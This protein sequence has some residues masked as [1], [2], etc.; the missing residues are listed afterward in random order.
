VRKVDSE[1]FA[2]PHPLLTDAEFDYNRR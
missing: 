1:H 2:P